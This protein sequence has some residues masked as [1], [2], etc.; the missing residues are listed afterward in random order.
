MKKILTPLFM[1][2]ILAIIF[3]FVISVDGYD[4][5][6]EASQEPVYN[7]TSLQQLSLDEEN[8]EAV[9]NNITERYELIQGYELAGE[10][11][12]TYSET[13][14]REIDPQSPMVAL[15]FDDGP[16]VYT[17]HIRE[18]FERYDGLAT[19]FVMGDLVSLGRDAVERL[20]DSGFE[21]VGHSWDHSDF[22]MLSADQIEY[23]LEATHSEIESIIGSTPRLIR[24]PY[25]AVNQSVRDI[26]AT[27]GF[28]II[29]WSMDPED[30]YLRNEYYIYD[31]IIES[32]RDGEIVV[33][34]DIHESTAI[35][36]QRIVP[37]LIEA[38]YQLVTISELFYYSDIPL[39]P[40]SVYPG[41]VYPDDIN[42]D[43][44]PYLNDAYLDSILE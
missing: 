2:G 3:Y 11:V 16:G 38:G 14:T 20:A 15:T 43:A 31:F 6:I 21:V 17:D 7:T 39:V 33:L 34:H 9:L 13:L 35:A 19:F 8:E 12:D 30:W 41:S 23:Q 40:G 4:V 29:N 44:Y 37:T 25:G 18:V 5:A 36:I 42:L 10:T 24:P 27:L 1:F 32:V 26:S 22:T 28:S